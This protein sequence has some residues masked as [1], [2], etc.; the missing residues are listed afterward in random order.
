MKSIRRKCFHECINFLCFILLVSLRSRSVPCWWLNQIQVCEDRHWFFVINC[1]L[2]GKGWLLWLSEQDKQ[3]QNITET[4]G[5][6]AKSSVQKKGLVSWFNQLKEGTLHVDE[7]ND[8]RMRH[9]FPKGHIHFSVTDMVELK[10][11]IED[12]NGVSYRKSTLISGFQDL[13]QG[14]KQL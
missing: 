12:L 14:A 5:T 6:N 4:L 3:E 11:V 7:D 9:L 10:W 1:D 8:S 2:R 13:G